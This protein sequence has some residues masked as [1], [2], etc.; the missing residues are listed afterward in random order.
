M[1]WGY[2]LLLF[3]NLAMQEKK[4]VQ[5][6][7]G[8]LVA[9]PKGDAIQVLIDQGKKFDVLGTVCNRGCTEE[10]YFHIN[11][12]CPCTPMRDMFGAILHVF[13]RAAIV[14]PLYW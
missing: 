8:D 5:F 10:C 13:P 12:Q 11:G 1:V 4:A 3:C 6:A 9:L 14:P 7:N 2:V